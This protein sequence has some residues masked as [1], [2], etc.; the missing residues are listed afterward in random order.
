MGGTHPG[1]NLVEQ[2]SLV[3]RF[4]FFLVYR[5]HPEFHLIASFGKIGAQ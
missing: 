3:P 5:F 4:L 1:T 2:V